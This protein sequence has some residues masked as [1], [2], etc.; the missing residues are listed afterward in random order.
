MALCVRL[1]ELIS[2][3]Q[4]EDCYCRGHRKQEADACFGPGR[5]SS[6]CIV[7]H[8]NEY[9]NSNCDGHCQ[10]NV[11]RVKVEDRE[12]SQTEPVCDAAALDRPEREV[13]LQRRHQH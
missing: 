13:H 5:G 6:Q 8:K 1:G 9:K 11:V 2:G 12:A 10:C 4:T 7:Y 3:P